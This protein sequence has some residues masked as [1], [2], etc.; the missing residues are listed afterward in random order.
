MTKLRFG[1][2]GWLRLN[3]EKLQ[4]ASESLEIIANCYERLPNGMRIVANE[5]E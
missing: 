1:I 3:K 2:Y 5:C 4:E